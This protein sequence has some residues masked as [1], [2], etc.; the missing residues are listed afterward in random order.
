MSKN[1]I[2]PAYYIKDKF[3]SLKAKGLY[4]LMKS[5]D[6]IPSKEELQ[7]ISSD[8]FKSFDNAWKELIEMGYLKLQRTRVNN[9]FKY[10][11]ELFDY[12]QDTPIQVSFMKC[13]EDLEIIEVDL[14]EA[15]S[16][17]YNTTFCNQ[18]KSFIKLELIFI[19][20]MFSSI[21]EIKRII[22]N[23]ENTSVEILNDDNSVI[24]E[25]IFSKIEI[26]DTDIYF[27]FTKTFT[28]Y[29]NS[30][31]NKKLSI[32]IR[33]NPMLKCINLEGICF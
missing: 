21:Y 2:K 7:K 23:I 15:L 14:I 10:T 16:I 9:G 22:E 28:D 33:K 17:L 6:K 20:Y 1:N 18:D 31:S 3:L 19:E 13:F 30:L 27:Y 11:R 25:K 5:Y 32:I 29:V 8:G 4:S 26:T 12:P 24:H